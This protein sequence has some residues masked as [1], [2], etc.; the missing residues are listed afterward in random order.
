MLC[1]GQWV[2]KSL[3]QGHHELVEA[4]EL[5]SIVSVEGDHPLRCGA[6]QSHNYAPDAGCIG[7]QVCSILL[8]MNIVSHLGK[9]GCPNEMGTMLGLQHYFELGEALLVPLLALVVEG[10]AAHHIAGGSLADL[11]LDVALGTRRIRLALVG[12]VAQDSQVTL[13]TRHGRRGGEWQ[14][15]DAPLS[16]EEGALQVL[17]G[18]EGLMQV[19]LCFGGWG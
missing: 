8:S 6:F 7:S 4:S 10:R 16:A 3:A 9:V 14:L 19:Q 15:M 11:V 5:W 17:K 1:N 18:E 13:L 12:Q 2:L